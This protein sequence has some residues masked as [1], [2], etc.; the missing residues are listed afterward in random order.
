MKIIR[1]DSEYEVDNV[2]GENHEGPNANAPV[3]RLTATSIIGD[4]VENLDGEDLGK[5]DNIMINVQNGEIDYI[6]L[7]FG[8][9]LGMGGKL[10][11]IPYKHLSLNSTK[12]CFVMNRERESFK[13][14]PGFDKNHWPNTNDH[15][16]YRDVDL[17]WGTTG[18]VGSI[19]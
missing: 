4:K 16:Y 5:I 13:N 10:F 11:A 15:A 19:F 6:V 17:Y 18:D 7:E 14:M 3:R 12:E 8:S 2:T 1:K 9:L